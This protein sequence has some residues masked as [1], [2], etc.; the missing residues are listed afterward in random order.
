MYVLPQTQGQGVGKLLINHV[1]QL[2]KQS[3][4]RV[5]SLE[6]NRNNPAIEFY[7]RLGFKKVREEN[8]PIGEYMMEYFLME[9]QLSK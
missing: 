2:A 8:T 3:S 9:K 5:L 6:V 7:E 4:H 1:V